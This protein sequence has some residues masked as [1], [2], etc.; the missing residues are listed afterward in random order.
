MGRRTK[1]WVRWSLLGAAVVL[2][3]VFLVSQR[4]EIDVSYGRSPSSPDAV[5][6]GEAGELS[7]ATVPSVEAMT[8]MVDA[9]PVVRLPGSIARW[10]EQVVRE[11]IGDSDIR[12]L[13]APP[14]L[15]KAERGR[16]RDVE[17]ATITIVGTKVSGGVYQAT[18]DAIPEWRA[19]FASGDV[20]AL[21]V[22]MIHHAQER[23]SPTVDDSFSWRQ[24]SAAE[25]DAVTAD[26]RANG[27]HVAE[28]ATLEG[29]P[30]AATATAFPDADALY[31][32]LPQQPF[33]QP[34]PRYGPALAR[35]FP[36][37]PIVVMYGSWIEYDGPGAADFAELVSAMFYSQFGT[38]LAT[39]DYPQRNVLNA[40]LNRVTDVRY[41]GL[42]DRPLP[43]L[44][45]DPL[46]VT[47]P[48]L[49]WLFA[50][51]VAG[52]LALSARSL[53][54]PQAVSESRH[55]SRLAGLTALAIEVSGL[56]GERSDPP[57]T[58]GIGKLR[59]ATEALESDLPSAQVRT[60]L[61]D[62]ENE[63]DETA[64]LL[65]RSDYRPRNYL[66]G[67]LG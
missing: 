50:V 38:R 21:L 43:Y 19:Q 35:A 28:G 55:Y 60:L 33:G 64:R 1:E 23:E 49:P 40:W 54:R 47:M 7:E 32:A 30:E 34:V 6:E 39:Y 25:L 45:F 56:S 52:F 41:A 10:D 18:A 51:C 26:L 2:L 22:T 57:L 36:D 12:I 20:T 62:A 4:E 63:L 59:A 16:V 53:R 44:P 31:V 66:E 9:E 17:R 61:D 8:A 15:D 27:L 11:A 24:P 13:V 46:K 42:F 67:R 14:G 29:V 48:A 58:R 65:G 37:R 5:V 3:V